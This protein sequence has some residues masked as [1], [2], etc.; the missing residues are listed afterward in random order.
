MSGG[1]SGVPTTTGDSLLRTSES[2]GG[3]STTKG[4]LG[5][6]GEL[7]EDV[8]LSTAVLLRFLL[9]MFFCFLWVLTMRCLN[10][11]TMPMV[12]ERDHDA[13][14]ESLPASVSTAFTAEA[15]QN[16]A[17]QG[18]HQR[19]GVRP[20]TPQWLARQRNPTHAAYRAL[21]PTPGAPRGASP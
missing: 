20:Q 16:P 2:V 9:S 8:I 21:P 3:L 1:V 14:P 7:R 19:L 11:P 6:V 5:G 15:P 4:M 10:L 17:R 13:K 12:E 18:L